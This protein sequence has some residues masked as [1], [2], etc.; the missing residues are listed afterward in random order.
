MAGTD[1]GDRRR[2]RAAVAL[3]PVLAVLAVTGCADP[4]AAK[5]PDAISQARTVGPPG[6]PI[7]YAPSWLPDGY[8]EEGRLVVEQRLGGMVERT[9]SSPASRQSDTDHVYGL[10]VKVL[11]DDGPPPTCTPSRFT[12]EVDVNGNRGTYDR[13]THEVCFG[14]DPGTRVIVDG[15][16]SME[17]ADLLR[18]A[19][20]VRPVVGLVTMPLW[21]GGNHL[22][23]LRTTDLRRNPAQRWVC[24]LDFEH[25][26]TDPLVNVEIKLGTAVYP[27]AG[28]DPVRVRGRTGRHIATVEHIP[29]RG[30]NTDVGPEKPQTKYEDHVAVDLGNALWLVVTYMGIDAPPPPVAT[31]VQIADEAGVRAVDLSWLGSHP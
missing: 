5:G 2:V 3:V 30:P 20:S 17:Q 27:P 28:G 9:W 14:P 11:P 6:V 22:T 31:L 16:M 15:G 24:S 7:G 10:S 1:P 12:D 21:P 26:S 19:R 23:P 8:Q 18:I 4:D 13:I 25:R 29:A